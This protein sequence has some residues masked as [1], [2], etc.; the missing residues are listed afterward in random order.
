MRR[1]KIALGVLILLAV[2]A[3]ILQIFNEDT[4][5]I[6]T[7]YEIIAFSLTFTAV[8]LAILQGIDNAR[9]TRRLEK[10]IHEMHTLMKVEAEDRKKDMKLK[11][12]IIEELKLDEAELKILEKYRKNEEKINNS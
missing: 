4:G 8:F 7:V 2:V 6:G 9:T 1:T 11:K 5:K 12:E 10:L 3:V